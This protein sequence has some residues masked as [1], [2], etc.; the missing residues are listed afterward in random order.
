MVEMLTVVDINRNQLGVKSRE[1]VHR[2]GDWHE[3]FQCWF[4]EQVENTY[5]IYVQKRSVK[6]KT[7]HPCT[8][9]QLQGISSSVKQ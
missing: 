5:Y 7:I 8:T 1:A 4:I 3:T 9:S 6:K 2:D